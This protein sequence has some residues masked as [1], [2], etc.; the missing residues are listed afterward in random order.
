MQSKNSVMPRIFLTGT[1]TVLIFGL[2]LWQYFH[3]GVP[4]HHIL[5]QKDLPEISNWWG[6]LLLPVLTWIVSGRI[7]KRLSKQASLTQEPKNQNFKTIG[8]FLLGLI[9]GISI[10]VSFTNDYKL[11]L[12]NVLYVFLVLSLIFPLYY[13]EFILGFILG[14]TYTF[15]AIL[16]TV[17]IL[18]IAALGFL[19]YQFIRPLMLRAAKVFGK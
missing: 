2:L 8:L 11:F 7:E 3:S 10:A 6:G 5:Q 9:L 1:I 14:M 15:G 13:A 4:S 19:I 12:D 16:P 18:I 17:F